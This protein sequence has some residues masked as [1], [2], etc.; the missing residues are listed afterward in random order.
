MAA[1]EA[2]NRNE[3]KRNEPNLGE[4]S[5][6]HSEIRMGV[7]IAVVVVPRLRHSIKPLVNEFK[8]NSFN[9]DVWIVSYKEQKEINESLCAAVRFASHG[10]VCVLCAIDLHP[11]YV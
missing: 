8:S 5:E 6:I 4:T 3:Y 1:A 10:I 9:P 11:A 7:F 2:S